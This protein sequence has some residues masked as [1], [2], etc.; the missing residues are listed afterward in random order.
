MRLWRGGQIF[1]F[2][3]TCVVVVNT[4]A[5]A[6]ECVIVVREYNC[7]VWTIIISTAPALLVNTGQTM[8]RQPDEGSHLPTDRDFSASTERHARVAS[9]SDSWHFADALSSFTK[10]P[11]TPVWSSTL[12]ALSEC[13]VGGQRKSSSLS[14]PL[15]DWN[16]TT[17]VCL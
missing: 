6:C 4:V 17:V 10:T 14:R 5:L 2:A 3:L 15:A 8:T 9:T 11:T 1:G 7:T 16:A 13:F 12:S